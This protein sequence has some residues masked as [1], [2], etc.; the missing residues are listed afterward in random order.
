[1]NGYRR[2][3]DRRKNAAQLEIRFAAQNLNRLR[4]Y[5]SIWHRRVSTV[6]NNTSKQSICRY[7]TS[8]ANGENTCALFFT[9]RHVTSRTVVSFQWKPIRPTFLSLAKF[10]A[11]VYACISW[12]WKGPTKASWSRVTPRGAF[13]LAATWNCRFHR[14]ND[15][16]L[17]LLAALRVFFGT[18]PTNPPVSWIPLC[19][20]VPGRFRVAL[21][22]RVIIRPCVS[23][24]G[25]DDSRD[26]LDTRRQW[27]DDSYK[28]SFVRAFAFLLLIWCPA[29]VRQQIG[30]VQI[31]LRNWLY[32]TCRILPKENEGIMT[33]VVEWI[34]EAFIRFI[35]DLFGA[36]YSRH[37][38]I[39]DDIRYDRWYRID[40]GCFCE[41][42]RVLPSFGP[43]VL[44]LRP[45][46]DE[47]RSLRNQHRLYRHYTAFAL[48]SK[49]LAFR[50]I[51]RNS[52]YRIL[53]LIKWNIS[54]L[55]K[56][57]IRQS[58]N[59]SFVPVF[60]FN[61]ILIWCDDDDDPTSI[62]QLACDYSKFFQK[63]DV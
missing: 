30:G 15:T 36:G 7:M 39:N 12:W 49:S 16:A 61:S 41:F 18:L 54:L 46:P 17:W 38:P 21:N 22:H 32:I 63:L 4:H 62:E 47:T 5:C 3:S 43:T 24:L 37:D 51:P 60:L 44:S 50:L 57:W 13:V 2:G 59:C 29:F 19:E 48:T 58:I 55:Y 34:Y 31:I 42:I 8:L 14:V 23:L 33:E 52:R 27:R 1:M 26:E 10:P 53:L 28:V 9:S 40:C 6:P 35:I 56:G 45:D 20:G 11:T 25:G